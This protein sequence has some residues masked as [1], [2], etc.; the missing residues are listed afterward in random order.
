VTLF[1]SRS[2]DVNERKAFY[3]CVQLLCYL[4]LIKTTILQLKPLE[5]SFSIRCPLQLPIERSQLAERESA[6]IVPHVRPSPLTHVQT[7][8]P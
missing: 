8:W 4:V 5:I 1:C 2:R 7:P 6:G 3:Q